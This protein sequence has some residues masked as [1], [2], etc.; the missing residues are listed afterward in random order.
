MLEVLVRVQD[1]GDARR[2]LGF[3]VAQRLTDGRQSLADDR[4]L[5]LR[6][7]EVDGLAVLL[8]V[9][10][11]H[12][13]I[14]PVDELAVGLVRLLPVAGLELRGERTAHVVR[15]AQPD[16]L[17]LRAREGVLL[18]HGRVVGALD[19]FVA[20]PRVALELVEERQ[21]CLLD[22]RDELLRGRR[23]LPGL[24]RGEVEL[25]VGPRLVERLGEQTLLLGLPAQAS[26]RPLGRDELAEDV[27]LRILEDADL[28]LRLERARGVG[29]GGAGEVGGG[30]LRRTRQ[31]VA[32]ADGIVEAQRVAHPR[33]ADRDLV[34][35]VLL[36][37]VLCV[38]AQR[39]PVVEA[40]VGPAVAVDVQRELGRVGPDDLRRQRAGAGTGL[41]HDRAAGQR[42]VLGVLGGALAARQRREPHLDRGRALAHAAERRPEPV[43]VGADRDVQRP[44]VADP[45][46]VAGTLVL[47]ILARVVGGEHLV[48]LRGLRREVVVDPAHDARRRDRTGVADD[49]LHPV[50]HRGGGALSRPDVELLRARRLRQDHLG[51]PVAVGHLGD[52][53]VR[54]AAALGD[55]AE[56]EVRAQPRLGRQL[57]HCDVQLLGGS[58]RVDLV[59]LDLRG[60]LLRLVAVGVEAETRGVAVL[61]DLRDLARDVAVAVESGP[62]HLRRHAVHA[63]GRRPLLRVALAQGEPGADAA[64]QRSGR[65]AQRVA[66]ALPQVG[67]DPGRVGLALGL[68]GRRHG[69]TRPLVVLRDVGQLVRD[70]R[71]PE[72]RAR[73]V[74]AARERDV[75]A[76]GHGRRPV[77]L[78]DLAAQGVGVH[79][80][81]RQVGAEQRAHARGDRR[82]E[83][84]ARPELGQCAAR[85]AGVE[86]SAHQQ[87]LAVARRR[88]AARRRRHLRGVPARAPARDPLAHAVGDRGQHLVEAVGLRGG[89]GVLLERRLHLGGRPLAVVRDPV[90]DPR[91]ALR[92]EDRPGQL[93]VH[94]LVHGRLHRVEEVVLRHLPRARQG[95]R[96]DDREA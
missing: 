60:E 40:H 27:A 9:D 67:G 43:A 31:D 28:L 75:A 51:R 58:A 79:A 13:A 73:L 64:A 65:G 81:V 68:E 69:R 7:L 41:E 52:A 83:R 21:R 56:L 80:G 88:A 93:A 45:H 4:A 66:R 47:G 42:L 30:A 29:G 37:A 54:Q 82:L 33:A 86:R 90:R 23:V 36:P 25:G 10:V 78:G 1:R 32:V 20:A 34:V 49:Q 72:R 16:E 12:P 44:Q 38:R 92:A 59:D 91:A 39:Q 84:A 24:D 17:L 63:R 35:A 62:D 8:A 46:E 6:L 76:D 3:E 89:G 95:A 85:V 87:A 11:G 55:V 48:D 15:A 61:D 57:R 74:R 96:G 18:C 26:E 19:V 14:E 5:G 53:D 77:A 71:I 50:P 22:G 94:D 70:Q 2:L